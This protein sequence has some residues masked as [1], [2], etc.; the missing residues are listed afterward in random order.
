MNTQNE[1]TLDDVREIARTLHQ[2]Q[3]DKGGSPYFNH[4]EAVALALTDF[5][6][7]AMCAGYLHD[8]IEDCDITAE[9][10]LNK[11]VPETVV[12]A[13]C[14]VSRNLYPD[15][16]YMDMIRN[17]ASSENSLACLVKIAD[18]AHNSR[19]DRIIPGATTEMLEFSANR[20]ARARKI[21]YP[22][23]SVEDIK[24]I[25]SRVNPELLQETFKG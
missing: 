15:A 25:L 10:L 20:Y 12:D 17:I 22:V 16:T 23:V 9:E 21:L 24:K 5:G 19:T 2:G 8:V 4:V 7:E 3:V 6:Y 1:A 18:N 13:V 14:L 11:G